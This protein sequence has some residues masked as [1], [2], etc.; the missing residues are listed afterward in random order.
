[1]KII[2]RN[3]TIWGQN[4]NAGIKLVTFAS[5]KKARHAIKWCGKFTSPEEAGLAL[6][7]HCNKK[8][9]KPRTSTLI[10]RSFGSLEGKI[11]DFMV[12]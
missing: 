6:I 10:S 12:N 1:M 11:G 2:L 5:P 8:G 9:L 3:N 7:D 4:K